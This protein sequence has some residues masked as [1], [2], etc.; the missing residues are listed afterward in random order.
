MTAASTRGIR[1]EIQELEGPVGRFVFVKFGEYADEAAV[2]ARLV[3]V[4]FFG[5]GEDYRFRVRIN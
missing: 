1:Y 2:F 4:D 3:L 5:F